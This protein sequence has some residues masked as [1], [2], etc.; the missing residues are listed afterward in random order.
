MWEFLKFIPDC[1]ATLYQRKAA[2][3]IPN[4]ILELQT[5]TSISMEA[6]KKGCFL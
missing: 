2:F 4:P 5:P 3:L 6:V 1:F